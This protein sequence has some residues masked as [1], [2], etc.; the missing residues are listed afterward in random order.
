MSSAHE[1]GGCR[2]GVCEELA[3]ETEHDESSARVAGDDGDCGPDTV[4]TPNAVGVLLRSLPGETAAS[5][6]GQLASVTAVS[7]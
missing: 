3:A 4:D 7:S 1:A 2:T 5:M 6:R